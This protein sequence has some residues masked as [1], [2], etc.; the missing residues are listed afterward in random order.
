M[1]R[2][3]RWL[4]TCRDAPL[5]GD[6]QQH[7][8]PCRDL[9]VRASNERCWRILHQGERDAMRGAVVD[10]ARGVLHAQIP[11]AIHRV[12]Q[13]VAVELDAREERERGGDAARHT[14]AIAVL[15]RLAIARRLSALIAGREAGQRIGDVDAHAALSSPAAGTAFGSSVSAAG[16]SPAGCIA[17]SC[18]TMNVR[19]VS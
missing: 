11:L 1:R 18:S 17:I 2:V 8:M 10:V 15:W 13:L 3:A 14:V 6:R 12:V 4:Q 7:R 5:R 9:T 19:M 16:V